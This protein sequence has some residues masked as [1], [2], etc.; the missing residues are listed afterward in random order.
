MPGGSVATTAAV[1]ANRWRGV[2]NVAGSVCGGNDLNF[3]EQRLPCQVGL[4][5]QQ[6][7]TQRT[8]TPNP[9]HASKHK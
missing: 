5:A 9:F 7:A 8:S 4:C 3:D 2:L 6:H 1:L